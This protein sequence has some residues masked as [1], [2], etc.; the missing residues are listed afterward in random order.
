[1]LGVVAGYLPSEDQLT[2][3]WLNLVAKRQTD[4][5]ITTLSLTPKDAIALIQDAAGLPNLKRLT[6]IDYD[7][8]GVE[9]FV[10]ALSNTR[11]A[12]FEL[13][14]RKWVN[15]IFTA[16]VLQRISTLRLSALKLYP[17]LGLPLERLSV[18][19]NA[20]FSLSLSLG[21]IFNEQ[22][23]SVVTQLRSL[24]SLAMET[25]IQSIED[26]T[27]LGSHCSLK[28]FTCLW[29]ESDHLLALLANPRL[30]ALSLRGIVE[31]TDEVKAALMSHPS[32][33]AL[34]LEVIEDPGVLS[35]IAR[36]PIIQSLTLSSYHLCASDMRQLAQMPSLRAFTIV[37]EYKQYNLEV[38]GEGLRVLCDKPL[39][40]LSFERT[41]INSETY[42]IAA[43]ANATDLSFLGNKE[44]FDQAA[45]AALVANPYVTTLSFVGD[46]VRG[47]AAQLAAAPGLEKLSI[48][49]RSAEETVESVQGAWQNAGKSLADLT[50][51][52]R[53]A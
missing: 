50:V 23:F 51:V 36:N 44:P 24:T 21:Q 34:R 17:G 20:D 48:D 16:D 42:A 11:Y 19:A 33:T 1:M 30:E 6:L 35:A 40:R 41:W 22:H 5:E 10:E 14:L 12:P 46:I 3:R 38:D 7:I 29:I 9:R 47:G 37:E 2:F 4:R 25:G 53:H 31:V 32:M 52:V 45:V 39:D 13:V 8:P 43:S 15:P 49:F 18:L 26:A 28:A 27:A